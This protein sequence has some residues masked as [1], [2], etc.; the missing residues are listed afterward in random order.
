MWITRGQEAAAVAPDDEVLD[1]EEFDFELLADDL[2]PESDE[3]DE[4]GDDFE[5]LS[6]PADAVASDFASD[7]A[8]VLALP[9]D[10]LSVR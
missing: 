9:S 5:P 8:S 4:E 10:L 6:P 2:A 1:D 7:L 3:E